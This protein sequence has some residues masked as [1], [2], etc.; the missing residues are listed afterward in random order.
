MVDTETLNVL[1]IED[2]AGDARLIREL[3]AKAPDRAW[4]LP[5]FHLIWVTTL[6]AG[7]AR[8]AKGDIDAVLTDLE[9]PDS[10]AH[11]TYGQLVA[12][13]PDIPVV[14]LTGREEADLA[15]R[16]VRAGAQDYLLKGELR[17]TLLAHALLFAIE[18][19]QNRKKLESAQVSLER[20]VAEQTAVLRE[21]EERLRQITT[22]LREAVWL[23]DVQSLEILY[24]NPAYE[25]IWGRSVE[26]FYKNPTSFVDAIH[27]EDRDRVMEAIQATKGIHFDEEY[28]IV[29]PNGDVR[30]IWGRTFPINDGTDEIRRV[31][32]VA[33][34][35]TDRKK[36]EARL[37]AYTAELENQNAEL[38]AF[39]HTV[40]HDLA[41]PLSLIIGYTELMSDPLINL[42]QE[43][44][45]KSLGIVAQTARKMGDI[46][47]DLLLLSKVRK[48]EVVSE[49]LEMGAVV[50]EALQRLHPLIEQTDARITVPDTWPVALGYAPWVEEV[51]VNYLDNALKYSGSR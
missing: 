43:Q 10:Q 49:P 17:G 44:R 21:S 13:A 20:R 37:L 15:R 31:V 26:S 16:T 40:A 14:V 11:E 1:V 2:H 45:Q 27:P 19:Q 39:A 4:N 24:V 33:E 23:R 42:S 48:M 7:L 46:I 47:E 50:E 41:T 32:A 38:D 18:R 8:L 28:R 51:W 35:I 9:L 3:L 22:S 25:R 29:R 30:W 6:A 34:D 36:T 5:Y 12:R